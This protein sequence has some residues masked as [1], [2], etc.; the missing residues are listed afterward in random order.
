MNL[1]LKQARRVVVLV[2]G[3]TVLVLGI[4]LLVLPGPA[5]IVIPIGIAILATEF[6]WA[7]RLLNRMKAGAA[8]LGHAIG[9]NN[10][11][12]S[13]DGASPRGTHCN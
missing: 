7:K 3:V 8:S 9:R 11:S 6:V 2:F 4:A 12:K 13:D 10:S 1:V 5:F